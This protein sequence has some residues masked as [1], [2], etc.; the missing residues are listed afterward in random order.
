MGQCSQTLSVSGSSNVSADSNGGSST[1][2][3]SSD[4]RRRTGLTAVMQ[5]P[6]KIIF[7]YVSYILF[8][9]QCCCCCCCF[10]IYIIY[11]F[12]L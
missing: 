4:R 12:F 9:Y 6:G 8:V 3:T 7:N 11:I 5:R 2:S 10:N 1:S